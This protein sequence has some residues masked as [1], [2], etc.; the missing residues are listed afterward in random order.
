MSRVSLHLI[1]PRLAKARERL[2]SDL[3][4][5]RIERHR[6]REED[7]RLERLVAHR[8]LQ[9]VRALNTRK[10][11]YIEIRQHKL[12]KARRWLTRHRSEVERRASGTA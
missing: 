12:D 9:L 7:L 2:L 1:A 11:A 5:E 4:R 10:L 6:W 8:E 3:R